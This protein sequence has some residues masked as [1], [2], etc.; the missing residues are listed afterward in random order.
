MNK[1]KLFEILFRIQRNF[2]KARLLSS[3]EGSTIL[4][5]IHKVNEA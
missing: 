3:T 2:I 1:L 4:T 5:S